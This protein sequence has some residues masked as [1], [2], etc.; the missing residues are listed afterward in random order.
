MHDRAV[1]VSV[2]GFV[3]IITS[4]REKRGNCSSLSIS[5]SRK[6]IGK[7]GAFCFGT[8]VA[9]VMLAGPLESFSKGS[10]EHVHSLVPRDRRRPFAPC[11]LVTIIIE[12]FWR[13]K[14]LLALHDEA[15]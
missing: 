9:L 5:R 10:N 6:G 2:A 3:P 4:T 15:K 8:E 7:S 1:S 14:S 13:Y 11:E 12:G